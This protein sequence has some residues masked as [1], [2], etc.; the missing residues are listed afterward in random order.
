MTCADFAA[1]DLVTSLLQC[2]VGKRM[3]INSALQ[4]HFF[5]KCGGLP[6]QEIC[7]SST[8]SIFLESNAPAKVGDLERI[9]IDEEAWRR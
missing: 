9:V 3:T 8:K 5:F 6:L 7:K 1:L 4:H 2:N